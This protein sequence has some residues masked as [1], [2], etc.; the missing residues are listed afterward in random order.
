MYSIIPEVTSPL[1]DIITKYM[2]AGRKVY[3]IKIIL[4][5]SNEKQVYF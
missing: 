3:N 1:S 5:N 2:I 4:V